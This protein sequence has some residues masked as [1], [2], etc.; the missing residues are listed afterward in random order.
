MT[1]RY[2]WYGG[3]GGGTEHEVILALKLVSF[4]IVVGHAG[5]EEC[6]ANSMGT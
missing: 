3:E 6:S 2:K 4:H 1:K 5:S